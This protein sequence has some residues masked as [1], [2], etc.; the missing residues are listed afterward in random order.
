[1]WETYFQWPMAPRK[2][3]LLEKLAVPGLPL[4]KSHGWLCWYA[5]RWF[6]EA[7]ESRLIHIRSLVSLQATELLSTS[8]RNTWDF[9][10]VFEQIFCFLCIR[11]LLP[12][13]HWASD[14]HILLKRMK[15]DCST[16]LVGIGLKMTPLLNYFLQGPKETFLLCQVT[17]KRRFLPSCVALQA[18]GTQPHNMFSAS[19]Q[20]PSE[21]QKCYKYGADDNQNYN[22]TCCFSESNL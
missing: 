19:V 21:R 9:G 10:A 13:F 16:Q 14:T 6:Q 8:I 12:S 20:N 17:W 11:V 15:T 4:A 22:D 1:M 2:S 3:S 7:S 5:V 18:L